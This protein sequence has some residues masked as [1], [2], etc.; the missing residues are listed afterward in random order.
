[1]TRF[2]V[3]TPI[4]YVN[5]VPHIGHVYTTTLADVS[6]RFQRL[7]GR[8]VFFLT[9]TDEH[10]SKVV[11]TARERGLTPAQWADLN[12]AEFERCFAELGISHDDFVRTTQARHTTRVQEYVARLVASGDVYLGEYEGWYDAGQEEYVPDAK[13]RE[14][15]F[16]SPINKKPLV[17][18][19]EQNFFFKLG[20]YSDAVLQ[21]IE[22]G[23][24]TIQPLGR[25]QEV[26]SRIREGL[27]DV[28]ISRTGSSDWGIAMPGHAEHTIYVWIDALFNYLSVVDTEQRRKYWP[29]DVHFIG[30]DILWFH[31]VIWPA[32]LL[33]LGKLEGCEWMRPPKCIY[34]HGFWI[35]EGEKMSKSMGNFV[36]LEELRRYV[37]ELGLDALRLYLVSQGPL[38]AAD[39][40]F[41]R[42]RFVDFYNSELANTLGN[43]F[44]RVSNMI[45]RYFG[46][47]V[48]A[49]G[50]AFE[51]LRAAAASAVQEALAHGDALRLDAQVASAFALLRAVDGF[52]QDTEPFRLAKQPDRAA[53][54]GNILYH[55]AEAIRIASVLL[56]P[57]MPSS[58]E[59]LWQ[60]MGLGAQRDALLSGRDGA[61]DEWLAWGRLPVGAPV[62]QGEALFPR[63]KA[64]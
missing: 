2:Y 19:R 47:K 58:M 51:P 9:G 16:R 53:E 61:V 46:G 44:S 25:R 55:A 43:G 48:P 36:D 63:V 34:A 57:V 23:E 20:Q 59:R 52:I 64:Q 5:D 21:L 60:R 28:P 4:Y 6:A 45:N 27:K 3:T 42:Q 39:A 32:L 30:K 10:A 54:V 49:P 26:L 13:A 18:K 7:R 8:D 40:D 24:M 22:S 14:L 15:D 12:A 50:A 62:E 11:D 33:A 31:A 41:A 29:A 37:A 38:G 17:K 1:M 35:R 56:W